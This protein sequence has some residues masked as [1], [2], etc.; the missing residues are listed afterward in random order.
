MGNGFELRRRVGRV[1][2]GGRNSHGGA[3]PANLSALFAARRGDED[4]T[5]K[6]R[7]FLLATRL[8]AVAADRSY[9]KIEAHFSEARA[10]LLQDIFALMVTDWKTGGVFVEIGVGDGEALS[11]TYLLEKSFGWSGVLV[12]PDPRFHASIAEKRS[13]TLD[14]RAAFKE[15][16]LEVSFVL[17]DTRGEFSAIEA[18]ADRDGRQRRGEMISVETVTLEDILAAAGIGQVDYLSVDT[19]GSEFEVLQGVDL[20]AHG[21]KVLT[22]EHN[23][24][25]EKLSRIEPFLNGQDYWRVFDGATFFDAWYVR[26]KARAQAF[27]EIA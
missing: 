2:R 8:S 14:K 20:A 21:V 11:N 12:E 3:D 22:V 18:F 7:R 13:A 17:D 16:G 9:R 25:L 10:Q 19:E 15:S 1:L 27:A 5:E 4:R 23:H 24:D 26:G 6:M